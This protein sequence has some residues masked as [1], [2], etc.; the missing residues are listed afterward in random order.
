MD[1]PHHSCTCYSNRLRSGHPKMKRATKVFVSYS[2]HDQ[3]TQRVTALVQWLS[4]LSNGEL[5]FV[6]DSQLS[7]GSDVRDFER[8]LA[9]YTCVLV[10]GTARYKQKVES[11]DFGVA[12][13]NSIIV[14]KLAKK[15]LSAFLVVT[16]L[17]F[18][19]VFP[20]NLNGPLAC[21]LIGIHHD[22]RTGELSSTIRSKYYSSAFSL[23][24]DILAAHPTTNRRIVD[25]ATVKQKLFFEQKSED[26]S[27]YL[28]DEVLNAIFVKTS[29]FM[30]VFDHGAHLL[31]GRKGS[32]KSFLTEYFNRNPID[33]NS[34][35]VNVHLRDFQLSNIYMMRSTYKVGS[36][37]GELI[38]Q[39]DLFECAWCLFFAAAA[40]LSAL[41]KVKS[42]TVT[43]SFE[44]MTSIDE[45][46]RSCGGLDGPNSDNE[47]T[48]SM[49]RLIDWCAEKVFHLIEVG[50]Q[51]LNGDYARAISQLPGFTDPTKVIPAVIGLPALR[52]LGHFLS[53]VRP[54]F[55]ATVDGFDTKFDT[56]RRQ[57]NQVTYDDVEK[58]K[59]VKFEIDWLS[60]LTEATQRLNQRSSFR[61]VPGMDSAHFRFLVTIP[62]DRFIEV[63]ESDRDG[64]RFRH[65]HVEIRWNGV[66]LMLLVRKRLEFYYETK[67][68]ARDLTSKF[69]EAISWICSL[70]DPF[71]FS[72]NGLRIDIDVFAYFLRHTFWRPRDILYH[73]A[74]LISESEKYRRFKRE[75]TVEKIR[76]I[77]SEASD[78]IIRNEF[79]GE[80]VSIF[81]DIEKAVKLFLR[82]RIEMTFSELF[83]L[84]GSMDFRLS[85]GDVLSKVEAK[86]D[87]LYEIGF[88]GIVLEDEVRQRLGF[89]RRE[90][91]SFSDSVSRYRS[92][93]LSNK[94]DA[95]W[96]IHPIFSEFLQLS[97]AGAPFLL[98]Y[99]SD[100]LWAGD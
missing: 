33:S 82:S 45:F 84:L 44:K 53:S 1:F 40:T 91:F 96:V 74:L 37:I 36:D 24:K 14:S 43:Y 99:S 56:F 8:S 21:E 3:E 31:I 17:S 27:E 59:R 50:I 39:R 25:L 12:R 69:R 13:E 35:P 63:L 80:Y 5:E 26:M 20:G 38:S 68:E 79:L 2:R 18:S 77:A 15:E 55:L 85:S 29:V 62:R 57:T 48:V 87:F 76:A 64:Y 83:G 58:I 49:Q 22:P 89:G 66:Q 94:Q 7:A 73:I 100:Y 32:G 10:V 61:G 88:L 75:V 92:L 90:A 41:A 70:P 47:Y 60:G 28:S 34:I 23:V 67:C 46:E 6:M 72:F 9:M 81:P 19:E 95:R 16:E 93:D 97:T 54:T 42:Q 52:E 65:K 86:I 78:D 98:N 4:Q 30:A 71:S 51:K 11:G